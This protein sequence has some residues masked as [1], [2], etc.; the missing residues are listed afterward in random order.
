MS[1]QL[2]V[3]V[4]DSVNYFIQNFSGATS[5]GLSFGMVKNIE[6]EKPSIDSSI[7]YI[8]RY[9]GI[10]VKLLP[11]DYQ[12]MEPFIADVVTKMGSDK[13]DP[14]SP[15]MPLVVRR[16]FTGL[17]NATSVCFHEPMVPPLLSPLSSLPPQPPQVKEA[18]RRAWNGEVEIKWDPSI[19][20]PTKTQFNNGRLTIF[21]KTYVNIEALPDLQ[22]HL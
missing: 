20:T 3:N 17:Q 15:F 5:I 11:V 7:D 16:L 12:G 9:C 2:M 18:L 1:D 10:Q 13:Y 6:M 14:N 4:A 22:N 19:P 21:F 8:N